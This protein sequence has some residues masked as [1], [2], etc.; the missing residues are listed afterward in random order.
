MNAPRDPDIILAAWLDE[1]AIPLPASTRRSI[2]IGIRTTPQ[3]RRPMWLPRRYQPMPAPFRFAA[4]AA[5]VLVVAVGAFT[6]L[7]PGIGTGINGPGAT[8]NSGATPALD[9]STWKLFTSERYGFEIRYPADALALRSTRPY[10]LPETG[11]VTEYFRSCAD[12]CRLHRFLGSQR[13]APRWD[14]PGRVARPL[15]SP[16][17]ATARMCASADRMG[18][19]HDRR[20]TGKAPGSTRST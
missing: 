17:S 18:G 6:L 7:R 11:D 8:S 12:R 5:A 4:L 13:G 14:D 16:S 10:K 20:T 19:R 3:W 2:D 15:L 1:N 9:T